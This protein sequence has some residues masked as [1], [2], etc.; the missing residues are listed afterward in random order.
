MAYDRTQSF[1]SACERN[2]RLYS[3]TVAVLS[4][5]KKFFDDNPSYGRVVGI[6]SVLGTSDG[7]RL[8][9]DLSVA[10]GISSGIA[11][12]FKWSMPMN[13]D[14]VEK[15]IKEVTKYYDAKLGWRTATSSVDQV[16]VVLVCHADDCARV[17]SSLEDIMKGSGSQT[18]ALG[19]FAIW[20]WDLVID[21]EHRQEQLRIAH[22]YGRTMHESLNQRFE[23]PGGVT[24]PE[25]VLR[26]LRYQYKF[27][28]QEPPVQYTIGVLAQNVLPTF[29]TGP[30]REHY[31]IRI[32]WIYDYCSK[33]YPHWQALDE[34]SKQ[35]KRSWI[36]KALR[37]MVTLK[38]AEST[39][40]KDTYRI[41]IPTIVSRRG[42]TLEEVICKRLARHLAKKEEEVRG[43]PGRVKRVI[44][45]PKTTDRR[46]KEFLSG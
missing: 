22:G 8:T 33:L 28:K 43:P 37:M 38:F 29:Q 25:D 45:R 5:I 20:T 13:P 15:E 16:G 23:T 39:E 7:R 21:K 31:N 1:A 3:D 44:L 46:I 32:D 2:F 40:Q 9:P 26:Y 17:V 19:S 42:R 36:V 6:E 11:F 24:T 10:L 30:E 4:A 27:I 12:E 18:L 34:A 41:R 14:L 35:I